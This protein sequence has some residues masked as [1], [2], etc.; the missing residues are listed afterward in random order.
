M[1]SGVEEARNSSVVAVLAGDNYLFLYIRPKGHVQFVKGNI[2]GIP[3]DVF[4]VRL[5]TIQRKGCDE[6]S[7]VS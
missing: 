1:V 5:P 3:G 6:R 4:M 7:D 2:V